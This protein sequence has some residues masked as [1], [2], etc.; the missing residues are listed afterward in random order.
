MQQNFILD[1]RLDADCHLVA[2]LSLSR[3]LLMN[4]NQYPWLIL[5]PRVNE[6]QEMYELSTEDQKLLWTE[7]ADVSRLLKKLYQP[8]KINIGALGN[9]VRQLHV[10]VIARYETDK[11]WPGPVWGAHPPQNYLN[12]ECMSTIEKIRKELVA[13]KLL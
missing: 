13:Q 10:H 8:T 11:S 7:I 2:D 5:V 9:I 3:L 6:V 4:D 1:E 12:E